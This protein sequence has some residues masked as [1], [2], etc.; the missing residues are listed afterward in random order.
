MIE[1]GHLTR[2]RAWLWGG[3]VKPAPLLLLTGWRR[4]GAMPLP[5]DADGAVTHHPPQRERMFGSFAPGARPKRLWIVFL[6]IALLGA[7]GGA[8]LLLV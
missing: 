1:N 3:A 7:S 8:F 5:D 6:L 2:S 4:R